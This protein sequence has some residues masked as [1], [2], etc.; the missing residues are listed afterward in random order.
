MKQFLLTM[1]GVFAGLMLFLVGV[2][3]LLIVLAAGASRPEP[4]PARTVV[5]LD[6]R[7]EITDQDRANPFASFGQPTLSVMRIIATLREAETD[8]HVRGLLVRLPESGMSPAMADEISDALRRFRKTG[9][10]V[11]V[12]SQGLYP[13]GATPSTYMLAAAGGQ[14]WMQPGSSLQATG[15]V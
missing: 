6:L 5:E 7:Q 4:V 2:P 14:V 1:A 3:F 15:M 11:I 8:D 12:F 13:A 10:P 9:K